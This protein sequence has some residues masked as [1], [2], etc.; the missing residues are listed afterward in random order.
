MKVNQ[1]S[2]LMNSVFSEVIGDTAVFA[3]DL[4]NVVSVGTI[5]TGSSLFNENFDNYVYKIV[6]KVGRSIFVDR[7]FTAKQLGL[8]R[9]AW[10]Y[11]S[12]LEKVRCEAPELTDNCAWDLANYNGPANADMSYMQG[13]LDELFAFQP[14]TVQ[15][16]YYNMAIT[17]KTIISIAREQLR[18][19][20]KGAA[21]MIRFI[22][23]IEN[24]I[25]MKLEICRQELE[26]R[27]LVNFAAEHIKV[28]GATVIH[29]QTELGAGA[30]ATLADALKDQ[31][32]LRYIAARITQIRQLM[33]EPSKLYSA[34]GAFVNFT[35]E[36][37]S[38]LVILADLENALRFNL[39]GSTFNEEF[40]KLNGYSSVPFWQGTG[41]SN[42]LAD[43]ST[44]NM[45]PA[46]EGPQTAT[47]DTRTVVNQSDVVAVL[48]DRDAVMVCNDEP[49]VTSQY[50][51]DGDF[52]NFFYKFKCSYFND[53]D[54]N[55][56][57]F[58]YD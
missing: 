50:N 44:I 40:V 57:V 3:E 36:E 56:I 34:S 49:T 37:D 38:R 31:D 7:A 25:R 13:H 43:R 53:L 42:T 33:E 5:I 51:A 8:W 6:D 23:M 47:P 28:S 45:I 9:D 11:A 14:P 20:F 35:P 32:T 26:R 29:L 12:V 27:T 48:C 24:R 19:A 41:T 30:P 16:K 10:E 58:V 4:A 2:S 17:F 39:Y 22:A 55:G 15:A 54:E 1:I 46:S 52:T 18:S 21:D